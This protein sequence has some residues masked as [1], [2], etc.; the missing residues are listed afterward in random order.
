[1]SMDNIETYYYIRDA[2]A[3]VGVLIGFG[4]T[5]FLFIRKKAGAAI[6][7][8]LGFVFL[9]L[10]PLLDIILWRVLGS[11]SNPNWD[12]LNTTYACVTGPSLFL[13]VVCLVLAFIFALRELKLPPP[14]QPSEPPADVIPPL[15]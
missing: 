15:S 12:T 1:M 7:S 2:V 8:L 9:G 6:L 5:I 11:T 14:P 13:G 4:A 3:C 10:E